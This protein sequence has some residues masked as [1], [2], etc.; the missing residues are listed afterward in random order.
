M[1]V[2]TQALSAIVSPLASVFNKRT[3][4]KIQKDSIR[5][6]LS[7]VKQEDATNITLT[8][9]EWETVGQSLQGETWKDEYVTIIIT[10]PLVLILVGSIVAAFTE[11]T[12]LLDGVAAGLTSLAALGV[13]M[14]FLMNAVVFAAV[15]LKVWRNG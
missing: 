3:D 10:S 6:K 8:D 14:G 12:R 7:Q 1:N 13:D 15:G 4:R 9:A 11:D 2:V 5:G